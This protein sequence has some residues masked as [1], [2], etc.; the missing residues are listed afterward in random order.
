[1]NTTATPTPTPAA[2]SPDTKRR[3]ARAQFCD[4]IARQ[5]AREL[6]AATP[7]ELAADLAGFRDYR[8]DGTRTTAT[9][10]P[11]HTAPDSGAR[12]AVYLILDRA[13]TGYNTAPAPGAF[14][15]AECTDA[16][17]AADRVNRAARLDERAA[18]ILRFTDGATA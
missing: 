14:I 5:Y 18:D 2:V 4:Q 17:N 7:D 6:A 16:Q 15:I 9:I 10:E 13:R 3:A 1:M 11:E 12:F 8:T